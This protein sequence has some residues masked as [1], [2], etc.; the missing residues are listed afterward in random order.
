METDGVIKPSRLA[1]LRQRREERDRFGFI[2]KAERGT[3]SKVKPGGQVIR[4]FCL[5]LAGS[6][7][8]VSFNPRNYHLRHYRVTNNVLATPRSFTTG[9]MSSRAALRIVTH[10]SR[11]ANKSKC[12][13][14]SL[15]LSLSF[16]RFPWKCHPMHRVFR[17]SRHYVA[18]AQPRGNRA[19]NNL[20]P[21]D[22]RVD[23]IT[24]PPRQFVSLR[25]NSAILQSPWFSRFGRQTFGASVGKDI[26]LSLPM[27]LLQKTRIKCEKEECSS[28]KK[29]IFSRKR[30]SKIRSGVIWSNKHMWH[31]TNYMHTHIDSR[32][33]DQTVRCVSSQR[34]NN[35]N[36]Q[37]HTCET[38]GSLREVLSPLIFNCRQ[39]CRKEIT[40]SL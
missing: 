3:V 33:H 28:V 36:F 4:N 15:I 34:R 25:C 10:D 14:S 8:G 11:D 31:A 23:R 18:V 27:K 16:S 21:S 38:A 1:S 26:R 9:L 20:V 17:E 35:G 19:S 40:Q 2:N 30:E 6:I 39:I 13:P 12:R 29:N 24:S 5:S 32:C 7:R 37:R 22:R